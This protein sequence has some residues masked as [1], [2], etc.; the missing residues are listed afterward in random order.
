[1][2]KILQILKILILQKI[3]LMDLNHTTQFLSLCDPC[4]NSGLRSYVVPFKLA[5]YSLLLILLAS[6]ISFVIPGLFESFCSFLD[7]FLSRACF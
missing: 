3:V 4:F 2:K 7:F 5:L 6:S 1:M